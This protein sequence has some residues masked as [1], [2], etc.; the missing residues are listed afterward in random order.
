MCMKLR[1]GMKM[2]FDFEKRFQ[3]NSLSHEQQFIEAKTNKERIR[4][5][6]EAI[7]EGYYKV[8]EIV[9][10]RKDRSRATAYAKK[11][12]EKTYRNFVEKTSRCGQFEILTKMLT[13]TELSLLLRS[14]IRKA[15]D[16]AAENAIA[17]ELER[18]DA[19][20]P[21]VLGKL[22]NNKMISPEQRSDA[23]GALVKLMN[24]KKKIRQMGD[25]MVQA[26]HGHRTYFEMQARHKEFVT[27]LKAKTRKITQAGKSSGP[28]KLKG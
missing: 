13:N 5:L 26:T 23:L 1:K 7:S 11:N 10:S 2:P 19:E 16:K 12:V 17:I 15:I 14:Y 9:A 21:I 24:T 3:E 22:M 28:R 8:V 20:S 25:S 6:D 4:I 27:G 18:P